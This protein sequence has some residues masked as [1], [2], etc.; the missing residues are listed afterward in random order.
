MNVMLKPGIF[1]ICH[2]CRSVNPGF[3]IHVSASV[4]LLSNTALQYGC[5]NSALRILGFDSRSCHRT[6]K[7]TKNGFWM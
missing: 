5:N 4:T 7:S 6:S 2:K 1:S 3:S